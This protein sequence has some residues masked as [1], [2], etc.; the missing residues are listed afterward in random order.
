MIRDRKLQKR[1]ISTGLEL[2]DSVEICSGAAEGDLLVLDPDQY[3]EGTE[4][5]YEMD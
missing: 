3:A 4:V 5:L 1:Y 2:E